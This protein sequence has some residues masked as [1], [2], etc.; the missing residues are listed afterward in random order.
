MRLGRL[1]KICSS[2]P[3]LRA[4][5]DAD[6]DVEAEFLLGAPKE[7]WEVDGRFDDIIC[8]TC[9][10]EDGR[11]VARRR[12]GGR[13]RRQRERGACGCGRSVVVLGDCLTT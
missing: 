13:R 11:W 1:A 4:W 9:W 3:A 8:R 7:A 10:D 5:D 2:A 6:V 12:E